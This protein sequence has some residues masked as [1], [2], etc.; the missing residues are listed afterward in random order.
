VAGDRIVIACSAI[1]PGLE[2]L[3]ATVASYFVES[4][5]G[6][7][8]LTI[9]LSERC[10]FNSDSFNTILQTSMKQRTFGTSTANKSANQVTVVTGPFEREEFAYLAA[11]S[12]ANPLYIHRL[13]GDA[14]F[15]ICVAQFSTIRDV[16]QASVGGIVPWFCDKE[17]R[18]R[19]NAGMIT[20]FNGE[21]GLSEFAKDVQ[22]LLGPGV[23]MTVGNDWHED[24][25]VVNVQANT[26]VSAKP[27]IDLA[28]GKS[29]NELPVD[30]VLGTLYSGD[31]AS[32]SWSAFAETLERLARKLSVPRGRVVVMCKQLPSPTPAFRLLHEFAGEDD[33]IFDALSKSDDAYA[34]DIAYIA[35]VMLNHSVFTFE[36]QPRPKI[37]LPWESI[38]SVEECEA[39]LRTADC[40]AVIV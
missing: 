29:V 28:A 12:Q 20:Q 4:G 30:V 16:Q 13:L 19:W 39:L 22:W 9:L 10:S 24:A 2:K 1:V 23:T 6:A 40:P 18:K 27:F 14:D 38:G 11:D 35:S 36:H 32:A 8:N 25:S 37:S 34:S 15:A 33:R 3:L 7:E 5:I 17:T 21:T 26:K 31:A